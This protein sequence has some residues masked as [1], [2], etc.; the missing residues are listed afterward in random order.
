MDVALELHPGKL[1]HCSL[2]VDAMTSEKRGYY[3]GQ[4]WFAKLAIF[5][6]YR[7]TNSYTGKYI[8]LYTGIDSTIIF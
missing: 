3:H 2:Q 8:V 5:C 6:G 7:D 1:P 4:V